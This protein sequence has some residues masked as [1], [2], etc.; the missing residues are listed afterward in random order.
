MLIYRDFFIH[1][2]INNTKSSHGYIVTYIVYT[3]LGFIDTSALTYLPRDRQPAGLVL[4]IC[5]ALS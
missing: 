1:G 3:S 5:N 2:Y 4:T